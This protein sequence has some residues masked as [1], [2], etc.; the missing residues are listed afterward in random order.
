MSRGVVAAFTVA[1]ALLVPALAEA[2]ITFTV[3]DNVYADGQWFTVDEYEQ[4]KKA[5]PAGAAAV[6]T[7]AAPA[8]QGMPAAAA[9]TPSVAP[10]PASPQSVAALPAATPPQAAAAP[11]P[12]LRAASCKTTHFYQEFP[13]EDEKF[14]CGAVGR[15]TRQEMLEQGWKID[16]VEKLPAVAGQATP[17]AYKIILSR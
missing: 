6:P 7:P 9:V 12:V 2:R 8:Q 3:G 11:A 14:D 1:A 15:L 10:P 4:Y 13:G 17:N 16:L 5:H